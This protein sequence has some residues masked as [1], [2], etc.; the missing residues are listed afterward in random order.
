MSKFRKSLKKLVTNRIVGMEALGAAHKSILS[1]ITSIGR[2]QNTPTPLPRKRPIENRCN[3]SDHEKISNRCF[4]AYQMGLSANEVVSDVLSD[5]A[6]RKRTRYV[7][8]IEIL[9]H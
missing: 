2:F 4:A 9:S 3:F 5:H 8:A 6:Q 1:R 7:T